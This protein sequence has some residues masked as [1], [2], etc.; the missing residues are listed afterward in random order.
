[1]KVK[2]EINFRSRRDVP[3]GTLTENIGTLSDGV[4][5]EEHTLLRRLELDISI[6]CAAMVARV[7]RF[8][9]R[10]SDVMDVHVA[11]HRND[12]NRLNKAVLSELGIDHYVRPSIGPG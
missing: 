11:L 3:A 4:L 8:H 1:M 9:H 6:D 12:L 7:I 2:L 10:R 5:I